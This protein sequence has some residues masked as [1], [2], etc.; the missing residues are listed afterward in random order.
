M[1][2]N[3]SKLKIDFSIKR[4]VFFVVLGALLGG[5]VMMM[6]GMI[7]GVLFE[8]DNNYYTVWI[9]FG[10]VIGVYSQ[11]TILAGIAIHFIT[12]LSIGIVI[13]TFLYKT[14]LMEI[15]KP[16]NGLLYGLFTGTVV[17]LLWSI[18]VQ[19]FILSP[20][21][22]KTVAMM[23]TSLTEQQ[24][25]QN[26]EKN[27]H[28]VLLQ[29]F[30]RNLLFGITLGLTSSLLSIKIGKRFR[31]PKCQISFSRV[32]LIKKH[33]QRIHYENIPQ[34]KVVIL[35]GGFGGV[36][37]LKKLQKGFE[38]NIQVDITIIN[39]D[40]FLLF[41][42]ML[43]EVISGMI[44]TSHIAIPLRS[45][46]K[47]AKFIEADVERIDIE[48]GNIFLRN[49]LFVSKGENF[50]KDP[51]RH[52]QI[53]FDYLLVS[54]GGETNYHNNKNI[55]QSSFSMNTLYDANSLRLHIISTLEQSDILDS[56]NSVEY[57]R[58]K[59]L[60]TY[61]VVGGGFSGVETVGEI[62]E[63]IRECVKQHYHNID[64]NDI[65]VILVSA[66]GKILP[67]MGEQLG[68]FALDEL[69]KA[70]IKI[71]LSKRV[72]DI[73]RSNS[74]GNSVTI[75]NR[76][77]KSPI[78]SI[79]S[80]YKNNDVEDQTSSTVILNDESRISTYTVIW[81][82]GVIP[83]KVIQDI[84]HS[85]DKNGRLVT[86]EYLQV[87]GLRNVFATGDCA[88]ITDPITGKPCPPTAQHA[89][90]QGEIAGSNLVSIIKY[91]L[92]NRQTSIRKF[93]YKTRGT[94]ATVG[95]RKG[96][97]I[98]FGLKILGTVAWM[99]WRAFYLRKIP[100]RANRF[101]VEIDWTEYIL[102]G[103]DISRLKTPIE[104]M[105]PRIKDAVTMQ[106]NES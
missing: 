36:E 13:G 28:I 5:I 97:A 60:L 33:L 53:E 89:I 18:P 10:H 32:D 100:A 80:K 16:L 24:I 51:Y 49:S 6:P 99:I 71:I 45:F 63:F 54:L 95:R 98:I 22:A 37:A 56:D 39:R 48:K 34:K 103:R 75:E 35:G 4:E 44:E 42:P 41:T 96:V 77:D 31:C 102:F 52:F 78:G 50:D 26:F 11:Y 19:Q 23:N 70:G 81:T 72:K 57:K 15:S 30:I 82:A 88:S 68:T 14:G 21:T 69:R 2:N 76:L 86:N 94:M 92:T 65:K 106:E 87:N 74:V 90:R 29:N 58:K 43:H 8:K 9:V 62:N 12:A 59:N 3:I 84:P 79:L 73:V 25:L 20:E 105:N 46:C 93:S 27:L 91:D 104:L 38:N 101:R 17:F 83:E 7:Y 67:E 47:R 40:N 61:V 55:K 64:K 66:S 85:K 1:S